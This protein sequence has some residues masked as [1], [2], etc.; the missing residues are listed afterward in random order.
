MKIKK[1]IDSLLLGRESK[2]V[3]G[4]LCRRH[5]VRAEN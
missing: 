1:W 3:C 4:T 5:I 2:T